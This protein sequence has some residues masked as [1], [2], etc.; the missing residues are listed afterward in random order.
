MNNQKFDEIILI[1]ECL[2]NKNNLSYKDIENGG[3]GLKQDLLDIIFYK[4]D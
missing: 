2:Q 1:D 4:L 3:V